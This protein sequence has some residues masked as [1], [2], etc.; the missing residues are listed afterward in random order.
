L[1]LLEE[2]LVHLSG[3][4][5]LAARFTLLDTNTA[6]GYQKMERGTD[7]GRRQAD[8]KNGDPAA[9]KVSTNAG[10][11]KQMAAR[12]FLRHYGIEH[13][14]AVRHPGRFGGGMLIVE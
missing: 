11:S 1:R 10:G 5:R 6:G 14:K 4:H 8:G 12:G 7:L 9:C 2:V 3:A 13:Q